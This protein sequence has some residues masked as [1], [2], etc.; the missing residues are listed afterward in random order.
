MIK[1]VDRIILVGTSHVAES[2]VDEIK[3]AIKKYNPEVVGIELDTQRFKSLMSET[4]EEKKQANSYKK[5]KELGLFGYLFAKVAG[6]VQTKVGDKINVDPGIDM[7]GAYETARDNKIPVAL[8]DLN[9]KLT[10]KKL[11]KLPF[12]KKIGLVSSIFFKSM[13]KEYRELLDFDLKKVPDDEVIIK[14]IGILKKETPLL[15]KILIDDRNHYMTKKLMSLRNKHE[16]YIM[17]VV[18]AGHVEGMSELIKKE[19]DKIT[20]ATASFSFT[21][22]E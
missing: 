21:I 9:I 7:K 15:Y 22:D 19:L 18:G 3:Q 20:S 13:K 17:A 8:I 12:Y 1:I 14:M 16:G 6:F 5:I 11:S 4:K 10:M 2:S